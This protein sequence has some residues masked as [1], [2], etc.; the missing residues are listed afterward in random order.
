MV[1]IF[2]AFVPS[3]EIPKMFPTQNPVEGYQVKDYIRGKTSSLLN[4]GQ[5]GLWFTSWSRRLF[6]IWRKYLLQKQL[7]RIKQRT[8][9]LK[10][11]CNGKSPV[12]SYH[13]IGMGSN[14]YIATIL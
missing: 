14:L 3:K 12:H 1:F 7:E 8:A 5:P 11:S 6:I 9:W 13:F 2:Q 4:K 10:N